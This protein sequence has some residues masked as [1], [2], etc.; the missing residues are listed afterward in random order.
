MQ[1]MKIIKAIYGVVFVLAFSGTG[2]AFADGEA[3][4][5]QK[6]GCLACHR[7]VETRNGPPYKAVAEKYAGQKNAENILVKHIL[8]GTGPAGQGWMQ[9]G[10]ATLPF[11][12][13]NGNVTP[14]NARKLAK[15]V[16]ATTGEIPDV[17][18]LFVTESIR[19][20]GVVENKLTLSVS[21]LRKF[22]P[23]QVGEVPVICQSGADKGKLENLKGVLLKDILEKAAI[24][25]KGHNDV[26]KMAIIATASDGYKVVFSWSE[27]FNSPIGEGV[28]VYF[29]KNGMPL[30]DDEGRIAMVSSKDIRTGPRHVKWL[31]AIEV[32]KIVE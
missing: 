27:V 32:R 8:K 17:S 15:W 5:A 2:T 1:A 12:P 28:M 31:E 13:P 20:S 24:V 22:P 30:G 3:V 26:K 11:M 25:T 6:S 23:Q 16:L 19:I 18:R 14:K 21:D 10:M 9:A 29:E 7:G 4:L